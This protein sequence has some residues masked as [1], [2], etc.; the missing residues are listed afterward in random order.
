MKK[1]TKIVF[2]V[3]AM[4]VGC[5]GQAWAGGGGT[6]YY[7]SRLKAQ[8]SSSPNNGGTVYAVTAAADSVAGTYASSST[9]ATVSSTVQNSEVA[10]HAHAK[11]S[12]G[13]AFSGWSTTDKGTIA[14]SDNPYEV[15]VK[16][17]G[18]SSSP[19][20][21]TIYAVFLQKVTCT[22]TFDAATNGTYTVNG[23]KVST[24]SYS[25]STK[26]S[27]VLTASPASGYK[28]RGWYTISNGVKTYF[29]YNATITK[30]FFTN[31]EIGV[32][33]VTKDTPIFLVGTTQYEDFAS[34]MTAASKASTKVAVLIGDGTLKAGDYTIPSGVTLLIPYSSAH[35]VSTTAPKA[36]HT[37]YTTPSAYKTL[38][39]ASGCNITVNGAI[40]VNCVQRNGV[41]GDRKAGVPTG[42]Y[43]Y[44]YLNSGSSITLNNG[45]NLYAYGFI[46][47]DGQIT[48]NS[49]AKVYED[50]QITDFRGGS[51]SS[52]MLNNSQK[53][54]LFNQYYI[55]NIEAPLLLKY[56]ANEYVSS[57]FYVSGSTYTTTGIAFIG[58]SG[59]FCMSSGST[60]TKKYDKSTD[61][62]I[63]EI[64]GPVSLNSMTVSLA[65]ESI[66][67]ASYVLP[68]T[69]N[70]SIVLKSG[71]SFSLTKN[72]AALGG[73]NITIDSGATCNISSGANLYVYDR[74]EWM[75]YQNC[76]NA[77]Y[78][79][80]PYSPT[81]THK[82]V[83]A[84]MVDA[85][86]RVNGKLNVTGGLYTT[87]GGANICSDGGGIVNFL[88]AAPASTTTYQASYVKDGATYHAYTATSAKLKNADE[89]YTATTGTKAKSTIGYK[90][91]TWGEYNGLVF[92]LNYNDAKT[93][94][95][96][97]GT[98]SPTT[99]QYITGESNG[100]SY[101]YDRQ[102]GEL[103]LNGTVTKSTTDKLSVCQLLGV[104][105]GDKVTIGIEHEAQSGTQTYSGNHWHALVLDICNKSGG[106]PSS[107]LYMNVT[108]KDEA[109]TSQQTFTIPSGYTAIKFWIYYESGD[110]RITVKDGDTTRTP[111]TGS[112]VFNNYKLKIRVEKGDS[113]G[114]VESPAGRRI[115]AG[116]GVS[117]LPWPSGPSGYVYAGWYDDP[118]GGEELT[119][120]TIYDP[121]RSELY[122]HWSK[123]MKTTFDAQGGTGG[124][125]AVLVGKNSTN[126]SYGLSAP[127]K[128]G[129]DFDGYWTG[130]NGTGD[131]VYSLYPDGNI[132]GTIGKYWAQ[133]AGGNY[134][135]F[136]SDTIPATLYAKWKPKT[137]IAHFDDNYTGKGVSQ[138]LF[139]SFTTKT[140]GGVTFT[141]ESATGY[142]DLCGQLS[143]N[144]N[145]NYGLLT[146]VAGLA[147]GDSLSVGMY[148]IT[149]S[150]TAGSVVLDMVKSDGTYATSS[151][152][153]FETQGSNSVAT[154]K[155]PT[156]QLYTKFWFYNGNKNPQVEDLRFKILMTKPVSGSA[157]TG[158]DWA[159]ATYGSKLTLPKTPSRTGYTF[160]GWW[161]AKTG[162]TQVTA[163]TVCDW[164]SDVTLYAHW[165]PNKYSVQFNNNYEGSNTTN[166]V[167]DPSGTQNGLTV[168]FD[169]ST[170]I[171]TLNGTPTSSISNFGLFS[172]TKRST[173]KVSMK[174]TNKGG[175]KGDGTSAL[176]D[177]SNANYSLP[178][179][180]I[181]ATVWTAS[182]DS[183]I[184]EGYDYIRFWVYADLSKSV[185][186]TNYQVKL[187]A[188]EG[189]QL[190][191]NPSPYGIRASYQTA[192]GTLP[193]PTREG[194][195]FIGWFTDPTGGTRF[196][197][198]TKYAWMKDTVLYAHWGE[199]STVTYEA[200]G[201]TGGPGTRTLGNGSTNFNT[202]N[203]AIPT[204]TGYHFDGYWTAASGGE[205]VYDI[206]GKAVTGTY[207]NSSKQWQQTGAVTLYAHWTPMTTLIHYNDG[208]SGT[209]P[210][211]N[212]YPG[213]TSCTTNGVSFS[214]D[215][216]TKYCT[217][218][219]T[220]TT[221]VGAGLVA[222]PGLA[223]GD[224]VAIGVYDFSG[225]RSNTNG[226]EV[227]ELYTSAGG[228]K[229]YR[230]HV[231]FRRGNLENLRRDT[232]HI[233]EGMNYIKLRSWYN[234][235]SV[236]LNKERF[237]VIVTKVSNT[238]IDGMDW[239]YAKYG[240]AVSTMPTPTARAGYTF[241]GWW[242]AKTGGTQVTTSTVCNW[243]SDTTLYAH[244]TAAS[245][246]V[247]F[248]GNGG[249]C[250]TAS[251]SVTYD[252]AYGDLPTPTREGYTF[253]GWWTA[254]SGGSQIT[255]TTTV[256]ITAAQ[257][258]Y[259]HWA[260]ASVTAG[261]ETTM[262][263][264]WAEALTA[265]NATSDATLTLLGDV[266][267]LTEQQTITK[268]MTLDL[269]GH[270]LSGSAVNLFNLNNNL[271]LTITDNSA[272]G[273][274][275]ISNQYDSNERCYTFKT[276][277]N[278]TLNVNGG[279]I[280]ATNTNSGTSA[281]VA[282]VFINGNTNC[283]VTGGTI[284][285]I[286]QVNPF[287]LYVY[288]STSNKGKVYIQGGEI[289]ATSTSSYNPYGVYNLGNI[290]MSAG[291]ITAHSATSGAMGVVVVASTGGFAGTFTMTGGTINAYSTTTSASGVQTNVA[292]KSDNTATYVGE[293]NIS[294]GTINATAGTGTANGVYVNY[295]AIGAANSTA[296]TPYY[297]YT[298]IGRSKATISGGTI[299]A[300]TNSGDYCYGVRS[301]GTTTITGGT[302][303]ALPAGKQAYGLY[304]A[305]GT[306]AVSGSPTVLAQ[307]TETAFGAYV[308]GTNLDSKTG[309]TG[310]G[311]L[312]ISGG[313]FTAKTTSAGTAYG[314]LV[315]YG[316]TKIET[317]T[318][319]YYP[320]TTPYVG[321]GTAN[322]SGGTFTAIAK[323]NYAF[324]V[325]AYE[326]TTGI[327]TAN[328]TATSIAASTTVYPTLKVTGGKFAAHLTDNTAQAPINNVGDAD[329]VELQGGHYSS[330]TSLSKYAKSPY[331]VI[332]CTEAEF[333]GTYPYEVSK[334]GYN[335]TWK[336]ENGAVLSVTTVK[337]GET[338]VYPG[339][340]P[341]KAPDSQYTYTWKGWDKEIVPVTGDATYTSLGFT[342]TAFVA[343]VNTVSYTS[344]TEALTA[345]NATSDATLTLLGDVT[346]LTEQQTITKSMTLDLNGHELSGSAVNLFNLNN[347]LELTITDNS[348]GGKGIISN[349]YDSNE[350][351]YTFKTGVNDTLN[352]NGGTIR[353]T[354]TNSGTSASVA[355]VFIN[356]N[357]NCYVTGGTIEGIAQVNPFGLYVYGSTSNKGKVY[358]Q[359][360]EIKAT[361][362]SS[363]NPYGVYNLGNI[364]MSAGTITAHS[365]T[366]GA[367]G[368]VVVA[369]TGGFAGTFTMTG[370]TINAYSTTTSAS[371]VQTNVAAKSDN[372][373]TYVGEA[374]ISGG[375]INATAG[376]GTANGVY[377]NYLAIGAA[378]STAA[379]PYYYYTLIGRSKATISGGTITAK[380]NSGDY[381]YG[382]RSYGTTTITGGTINALPAGKQAY[383]LYC[384]DGTMAVS[385]SPT[386]LAQATETAFGAYVG[387]TNLDSK[388][389]LTGQ[390]ELTISGGDFTAKT[391]SAGT[392][393][394]LLVA[395]GKTKIE[396]TTSGY[397]PNTTPYVGFGTANVSGGTFTAIAKSN[398]AFGVVAY[399]GTTG[400]VTANNTATSIAA[401]TTVYPTLKVTGG[402][403]AAHLTDNT[404]QAPIN[405]V[406]DADHVELQ[407]GHYSS[408][409]SLSKYAKSPYRVID[410]IHDDLSATYPYEV[411]DKQFITVYHSDG[412]MTE[413]VDRTTWKTVQASEP[414]ALALSDDATWAASQTNVLVSSG[415][416][417]YTCNELVLTDKKDFYCPIDFT[418]DKV[419]YTRGTELASGAY[420]TIYLP[421]ALSAQELA[422]KGLHA[423]RFD[424]YDAESTII[425]FKDVSSTEAYKPY[426]VSPTGS[427]AT[428]NYSIGSSIA[429]KST[430]TSNDASEVGFF[431][432]LKQQKLYKT[433]G[434]YSYYG[435]A[436]KTGDFRVAN[437]NGTNI[438]A[439]CAYFRIPTPVS[440]IPTRLGMTTIE[441]IVTGVNQNMEG[442]QAV[443]VMLNGRF[444]IVRG[445]QMFD[446]NGR[447]VKK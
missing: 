63:Y 35:I 210:S 157:M 416:S 385:G 208:Y 274:G 252:G 356:G 6:T 132:R 223:T 161:T 42:K 444:Y 340:A 139:P 265:A 245:Y 115:D 430:P 320:N 359:G 182:I 345:A 313:D 364:E 149:G 437:A 424:H 286:A 428:Q 129:Y 53:V 258:L 30:T 56:G 194:Y 332:Q 169:A 26:D 81:R 221:S 292:A 307:A 309:L 127:T 166:L 114:T 431:G 417:S 343:K 201:G 136:A 184:P 233:C 237:H 111:L 403:F 310:Q 235:G 296:A 46:S 66:N 33:F 314:L 28:V 304:C 358:I 242:T 225:Y 195:T 16:C 65:G 167:V 162:G 103:T 301:Y 371:G 396:T 414:N 54:F 47:G 339:E 284:E 61:R 401:S 3:A 445:E 198:S 239:S 101:M 299:T 381:C 70:M 329:H 131:K 205:L 130:Q 40:C 13:W 361:S 88:S 322:V 377:V 135:K 285:G 189:S 352:V 325:V 232:F 266:T 62:C 197:T 386:V 306:M 188:N 438:Y 256:A 283:Y 349:Q 312:T 147:S 341:T 124:T 50:F 434:G 373:A 273:K 75:K 287:G 317:T 87:A 397:Y 432:T 375:T 363:Y 159:I 243:T 372:T 393:Y 72:A 97:W 318:S 123:T 209:T 421:Y 277:V 410:C 380:T 231:D 357:T 156:D 52:T 342:A 112:W 17:S 82:R 216:N 133:Y 316:K 174:L 22:L 315:A 165:T 435:F 183:T 9:S 353:A 85:T 55:Q 440:N 171:A 290:E 19:T 58:T 350:R 49:G 32:D 128:E 271:E 190:A 344:W 144:A 160:A 27:V 152:T 328:N 187:E 228:N 68:L 241:A 179:N 158:R 180:R 369:S 176:M 382:V 143:N 29:S 348:A 76:F 333:Q 10:Y 90:D 337:T 360:G 5:V 442:E 354:N 206:D 44:L 251:K 212:I 137:V 429:V 270:E 120:G 334:D 264:T 268:S 288:G 64:T 365:A 379:T 330:Q 196:T 399:E 170:G 178:K 248:D 96:Y 51:S 362:T 387:G 138:N 331:H 351:C 125:T 175:T 14:S 218:D 141:Y 394:G 395:Y 185:T 250:S 211:E 303:N 25:L 408:Q 67:T 311:E 203:W 106:T 217:V 426:I 319:G 168:T 336:D 7:Y 104:T 31:S 214:Y 404:A 389:G 236:T 109:M 420:A 392:A 121:N 407:G 43:G 37:D 181:T 276:G 259:A 222:I 200:N 100:V 60:V 300:K 275:I 2:L 108:P 294:G 326:G 366:S 298:L 207:W 34:A 388:T 89:T 257:T 291:T 213:F 24:A 376:T 153:N 8:V 177:L 39:L 269:N 347:N 36:F 59:L 102:K 378:N 122:A 249:T 4:A 247:T 384:A 374:N 226:C 79:A 219:G 191:T 441:S 412:T 323:S 199:N 145:A 215:T 95:F 402:K 254:T 80:T 107:R 302:I 86:I 406:G 84:D 305:D 69:C 45:S 1:I 240:S 238:H 202:I 423:Q 230:Q 21:T 262:C 261:G 295:L 282:A 186:Y 418:A 400:I 425:Y 18:S 289:K 150:I 255:S 83:D 192:L 390:G 105:A 117:Y 346:G 443:K 234:T 77:Y 126:N 193:A 398:Y 204:R 253:A 118:T 73:V 439:F 413:N 38:T 321:F 142:V 48:A 113:W 433:N 224:R 91:G 297:Y 367:M 355:A 281:S 155:L 151:R 260:I 74:D 71:S 99:D 140:D 411:T 41:G 220:D 419:T 368:V 415:N 427:S 338:P 227:V 272:G 335:I 20:T 409:T 246:T 119:A 164:T 391:T 163:S 148:D 279:T 324:G 327:V 12:S 146:Q 116:T 308:G 154:K 23:T 383:G 447:Q 92:N 267:G 173:D 78:T 134:R 172:N 57:S 94:L 278:D 446:M 370:G 229:G 244:W 405:N 110:T 11:A 98:A 263:E 293:A 422:D 436:A 280:R 15:K 93:N